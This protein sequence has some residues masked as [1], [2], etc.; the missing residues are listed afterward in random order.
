MEKVLMTLNVYLFLIKD[1]Q[2]LKKYNGIWDKVSINIKKGF[3]GKLLCNEK[4]QKTKIKSYEIKTDTNFHDFIDDN[5]LEL[6]YPPVFLEECKYIVKE[7]KI[8]R[9][10]NN[11]LD[12]PD[13][14]D[15]EASNA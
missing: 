7:K 5:A 11:D 4:Y 6:V 2:L 9:F 14:S 13:D 1:E 12:S 3:D 10:I 15:E 8:T